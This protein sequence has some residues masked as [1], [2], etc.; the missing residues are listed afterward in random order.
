ML[1]CADDGGVH[2]DVPVDLA[3]RIGR[4]LDLLEETFPGS[5]TRPQAVTLVD[6]FPRTEPVRQITPLHPGPHPVQNPVDHLPVIPPPATTTVADRQ[7][8][9]QPFPLS[10]RQIAPP[11]AQSNDSGRE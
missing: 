2:R 9:P 7:E 11:H 6:G 4:G 5:V 1:M 10:I 8:R 3:Y